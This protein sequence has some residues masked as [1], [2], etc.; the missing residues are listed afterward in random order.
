MTSDNISLVEFIK[1]LKEPKE[2]TYTSHLHQYL[3]VQ[4]SAYTAFS[5]GRFT[6]IYLCSSERECVITLDI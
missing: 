4:C 5:I 2:I 3:P 1:A 6:V